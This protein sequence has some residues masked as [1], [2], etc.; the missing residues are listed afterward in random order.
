MWFNYAKQIARP[1]IKAG[2]R[3]ALTDPDVRRAAKK[4]FAKLQARLAEAIARW[5]GDDG[6]QYATAAA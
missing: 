4:A 2:V 1:L 3:W 6:L 5:L